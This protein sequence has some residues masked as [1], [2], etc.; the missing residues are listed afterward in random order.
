MVYP[1]KKAYDYFEECNSVLHKNYYA[2]RNGGAG[3]KKVIDYLLEL[4]ESNR[5]SMPVCHLELLLERF[6]K[7]N[8]LF[9]VRQINE[10]L[11]AQRQREM[12]EKKAIYASKS[13]A[14]HAL[15]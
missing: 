13:M 9:E 5:F 11:R 14:G 7:V 12:I 2:V 10:Q 4:G 6:F 3:L 15:T 8:M 1:T